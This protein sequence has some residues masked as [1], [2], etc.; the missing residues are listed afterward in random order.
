MKNVAILPG[1]CWWGGAVADGH[2]MPFEAGFRRDL[3]DAATNQ[4]MP[5]LVSNRGRYIWSDNPFAFEVSNGIVAIQPRDGAPVRVHDGYDDLA[6]ALAAAGAAH[7]PPRGSMPDKRLFAAPQYALWIE[8]L[9]EPTQAKV[10]A[11]AE[12]ALAHGFP[13]GVLILDEQWHGA[14]GDWEF[15]SGRF[16]D[17]EGMIEHLHALGF[18]V[19]LWLVPYVTPDAA[20][21]RELHEQRLLI[22]DA[23]GEP[24]IGRWWNGYSAGLDLL[25]PDAVMWLERRLGA[26][27]ELGVDGFKFDGGDSSFYAQLGCARPE[28]YTAA[29]NAIG[30]DH[31]LNEYRAGWRAAGLPLAQRQRDKHHTWNSDAGLASLIPHG[32]AQSLTGH[33]YHCPDMIGGGDYRVFPHHGS[34]VIDEE[35]FVRSAQCSALFPMMQ[36]S[37]APWR[38]L[39]DEVKVGYCRDAAML[40]VRLA[41]RILRLAETAARTGEPILRP[42]AYNFPSDAYATVV[43]QFMLGA[44]LLVAPVIERGAVRRSVVLPGGRWRGDDGVEYDGPVDIVVDAPLARLPWFERVATR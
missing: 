11:Y 32:V 18:A 5:L 19:S 22:C 41:E 1:E 27:R 15:H 37:A 10:I 26:L 33:A 35:L 38:V 20:V 25:K 23:T 12:Q 29:W 42:L 39:R 44:D 9:F 8:L 31:P 2:A 24:L 30:L 4:V 3:Q 13:P 21:F 7:F 17:P 43:D 28:A 34:T 6:G 40:H 36:F 14:Y 16:P